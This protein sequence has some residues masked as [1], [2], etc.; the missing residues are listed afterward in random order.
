MVGRGGMR[1]WAAAV[2]GRSGMCRSSRTAAAGARRRAGTGSG[3]RPESRASAFEGEEGVG[4]GDQRDVVLPAAVAAAL[5][6]VE[7]ERVLE[8]AVVVLDA[9]ADLGQTD[10]VG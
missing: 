8:L 10:E 3:C 1:C 6:V 5:E 9:P 2:V 4:D 7:A